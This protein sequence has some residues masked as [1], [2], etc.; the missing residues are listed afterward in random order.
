MMPLVDDQPFAAAGAA[1]IH[2]GHNMAM[3]QKVGIK[4]KIALPGFVLATGKVFQQYR[5]FAVL[6]ILRESDVGGKPDPVGHRYPD[7]VYHDAIMN[8]DLR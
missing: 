1:D 3:V 4:L 8:L 6:H 7:L 2:A 5:Q